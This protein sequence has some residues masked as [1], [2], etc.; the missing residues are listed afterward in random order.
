MATLIDM[1]QASTWGRN[2]TANEFDRVANEAFERSVPKDGM[3]AR[4]GQ[5]VVH[6]IG[7]IDGLLKMS[8]TSEDGKVSTLT[9]VNVGGWF[10]EG[11]L[12]KREPRRYDM[13][14]LRPSRVAM[15]PYA[16]F[17]WLR[18]NSMPFCHYLHSLMN[19]RLSLFIG[20]L[21]YDRLLEPDARA[22]RCLA[23]LFN[24][25]LYPD[26]KPFV[27]LR[28]HEIGLLS[29]LARSRVNVALKRLQQ[30][31]LIRIEPR[32]ITVLDLEGLRNFAGFQ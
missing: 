1:L 23:T 15:I 26:P 27:D 3:V 29:G 30:G 17:E 31:N 9:G 11:S 20:M 22:A 10:G 25:D 21:E 8:V 16:T 4:M 7:V 24:P 2:L 5:P 18:S 14:A 19:A 12:I 6:W 13:V 28:Q 32:G